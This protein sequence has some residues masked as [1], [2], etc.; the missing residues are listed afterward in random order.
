MGVRTNPLTVTITTASDK[1]ESPFVEMLNSCK[2]VLRGEINNDSVF[3]HIFEPDVD[4]EEGDPHTWRKVHPHIGITVQPDFYEREWEK[5]KMTSADMVDFRN[6]CLNIFAVDAGRSWFTSK[7]I[8]ALAKD[9]D[10]SRLNR[11]EA[12]VSVDLSVKDDFSCVSY[13]IYDRVTASFHIH[14][15]YYMP[16]ESLF[17]HPNKELYQKWADKGFLKL[18][19]GDIIDYKQIANDILERAKT[20]TILKIGYDPFKS[21][22]FTNMLAALGGGEYLQP[23]KQV[24]STFTSPCEILEVSVSRKQISF[25]TNPI[26]FWCFG[27]AIID[28]DRMGNRKPCKRSSSEKIDGVIT[29]LM[30]LWLFSTYSR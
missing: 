28:V 5:A 11:P 25:A 9:I 3:S 20:L 27:N 17:Y 4:D 12:M 15:D 26:T 7:Q 10:L 24:Y 29:T 8:E 1:L 30:D 16:E 22:E 6:K 14:T 2:A 23:V 21:I 18:C 13:G 19:K